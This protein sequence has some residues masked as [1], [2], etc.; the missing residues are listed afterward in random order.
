MSSTVIV[1]HARGSGPSTSFSRVCQ[2]GQAL[3]RSMA[4]HIADAPRLAEATTTNIFFKLL[5]GVYGYG[6][7]SDS[8]VRPGS[9]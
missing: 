1:E 5:R 3:I 9:V 2:E 8:R 7:Q 4:I 6:R